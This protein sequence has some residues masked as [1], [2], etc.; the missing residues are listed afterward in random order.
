MKKVLTGLLII[1][2][3]I[4]FVQPVRNKS[5]QVMPNDMSR[6][7]FV[8]NDVDGILKKACYDCH[9]NQTNYPWYTAIQP[10]RWFTNS[11]IQSGKAALNFNEFDTYTLRRQ[12][13]KLRAIAHSL[14]DRTMPLSSYTLVHRNAIL[15]ETERS[16]MIKWI[17][18]TTDSLSR[19]QL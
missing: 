3:M 17:Q 16:V 2:V 4:Q 7:V 9:S 15:S 6:V 12:Q 10:I 1:L 5:G 8:P 19:K 13:N 11:H 14:T 18:H